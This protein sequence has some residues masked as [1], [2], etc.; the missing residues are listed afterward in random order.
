MR[1]QPAGDEGVI[2][3]VEPRRNLLFRQDEWRT[4]SF[5][6]NLDQ[7]LV[8][9]AGEPVFSESQLARALIA[10]DSAGIAGAHRA[11]QDRPAQCRAGARAAAPYRAMG[12]QVLEIALKADPARR[13][14]VLLPLLRG[15][16]DAG[17]R[18][19]RH[20]QE[21]ADQPAGAAR[22]RRRSARSRRR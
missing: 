2:E 1:W 17:A 14:R 13:A 5:A 7:M 3:H 8:L 10:A 12:V 16:D 19:Q 15:K 4:K 20:R 22:R 11:E 9:V 18:P 6:A 21:H